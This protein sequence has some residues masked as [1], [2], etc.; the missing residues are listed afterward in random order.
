MMSCLLASGMIQHVVY[1]L[2]TGTCS[3]TLKISMKRERDLNS[4]VMDIIQNSY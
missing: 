4:Y 2:L 3:G 1:T